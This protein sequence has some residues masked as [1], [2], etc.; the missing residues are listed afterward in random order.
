MKNI[1]DLSIF[2]RNILSVYLL[3][4]EATKRDGLEWY[5]DA[6]HIARKLSMKYGIPLAKVAGVI[7]ATSPMKEWTQ[8]VKLAE[9]ILAQHNEGVSAASGGGYLTGGLRKADEILAL[10]LSDFESEDCATVLAVLKS[11]KISAFYKNIM[12]FDG[13]TVDGHA[14]NI[15]LY[16]PVRVSIIEA[17]KLTDK[18][19][20]M[21]AA[22]YVEAAEFAGI[23]AYAMQAVTWV[24]YK[25]L[26]I[27]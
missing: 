12:G 27:V 9:K 20:Q 1:A 16:G 21:Y 3:A 24:T 19:Y 8:N 15:A 22:A 5:A 18:K 4:D 6:Q 13:V 10:K 14:T 7:A 25:S 11:Q 2:A 26:E 17:K 23:P